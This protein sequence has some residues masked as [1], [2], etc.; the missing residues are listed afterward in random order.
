MRL[1]KTWLLVSL[2]SS[3]GSAALAGEYYRQFASSVGTNKDTYISLDEYPSLVDT[4]NT[5]VKLAS[6][7]LNLQ[8]LKKRG[9]V[10]GVRLGMTMDQVV[11]LWG[12]PSGGYAPWGC[13]HGLTTFFYGNVSL[14]FEGAQVETIHIGL[15][16]TLGGGLSITSGVVRALGTPTSS[17]RAGQRCCLAYVSPT[18]GL[19]LDFSEDLLFGVWLER[20]PRRAEPW[21]ETAG[22]NPQGGANG[23][24]PSRQKDILESPAAASRRSP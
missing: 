3:L 12:K 20:T 8:R 21:N 15:N 14:A 7:S 1:M 16:S 22:A 10:S 18:T 5:G 19:L 23:R 11:S 4:N 9:E 2:L 13:L 24:Q 17:R 6:A